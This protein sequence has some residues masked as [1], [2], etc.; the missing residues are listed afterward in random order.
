MVLVVAGLSV[1]L[2]FVMTTLWA[3]A[4]PSVFGESARWLDVYESFFA[5]ARFEVG[6]VVAQSAVAIGVW[7]VLTRRAHTAPWSSRP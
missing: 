7:V 5:I 6:G 2:Y 1:V 4:A 3:N